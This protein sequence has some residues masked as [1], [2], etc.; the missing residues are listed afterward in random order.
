MQHYH[1]EEDKDED[2]DQCNDDHA[3]EDWAAL[4]FMMISAGVAGM[5]C[6][7]CAR[8]GAAG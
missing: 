5:G 3:V 7:W 1:A 4:S 2:D 8:S 6:G